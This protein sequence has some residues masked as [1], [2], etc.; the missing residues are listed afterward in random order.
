M[1][2]DALY[3]LKALK[4]NFGRMPEVG[5]SSPQEQELIE[6]LKRLRLLEKIEMA[7]EQFS[8]FLNW[9]KYIEHLLSF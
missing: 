6:E 5:Q 7:P 3:R 2:L 8:F 4:K 1:E 9:K